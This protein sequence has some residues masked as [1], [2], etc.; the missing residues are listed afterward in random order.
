[1]PRD[2]AVALRTEEA[3][4]AQLATQLATEK[5]GPL[6]SASSWN[7]PWDRGGAPSQAQIAGESSQQAPCLE[8]CDGLRK[9]DC[10]MT[11]LRS[12]SDGS[13]HKRAVHAASHQGL[14]HCISHASGGEGSKCVQEHSGMVRCL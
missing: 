5:Q 1:V 3:S 2:S 6:R 11:G 14:V 13:G 10:L 8:P 7:S 12:C 9:Q 4:G